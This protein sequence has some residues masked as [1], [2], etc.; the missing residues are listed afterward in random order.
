MATRNIRRSSCRVP[1]P[2]RLHPG[3]GLCAARRQNRCTY[4]GLAMPRCQ[5]AGNWLWE[6]PL[7]RNGGSSSLISGPGRPLIFEK[8]ASRHSGHCRRLGALAK[9]R[10]GGI[11]SPPMAP[12][13]RK[14][15][16]GARSA[17]KNIQRRPAHAVKRHASQLHLLRIAQRWPILSI[18]LA[19]ASGGSSATKPLLP[20]IRNTS[21][22]R[23]YLSLFANI[24]VRG[25]P[26]R[27]RGRSRSPIWRR[28]SRATRRMW[29]WS[30]A[31]WMPAR[32]R[33]PQLLS[34][35]SQLATDRT[36]L[37]DYR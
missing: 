35:A 6:S 4:N 26:Q 21:C 28:S 27:R 9:Y 13:C 29:R 15:S 12:C 3:S 34:G 10:R 7:T 17:N 31:R 25:L 19:A 23:R 1:A 8:S 20:I 2:G 24:A 30:R 36:L 22:R 5:V 18:F 33:A 14:S 16:W 37:P 11:S 32:R